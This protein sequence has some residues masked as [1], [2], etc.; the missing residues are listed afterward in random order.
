MRNEGSGCRCKFN[1]LETNTVTLDNEKKE[2]ILFPQESQQV[3][4]VGNR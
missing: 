2:V 4:V 3:N 1:S